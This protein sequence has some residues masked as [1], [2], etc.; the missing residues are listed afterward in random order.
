MSTATEPTTYVSQHESVITR[1]FDAPRE[2][3]FKAWTDP[4]QVARWWG[5]GRFTVPLCEM[6][7]RPGGAY[8][9]QMR[10]PDG[11]IYPTSGVFEEIV[12][13]ER[14]VFTSGA[15]E[16][17]QG[18][19]QL[20][21]RNTLTFS[22]QDGT[23]TLT[24]KAVVLRSTPEVAGALAGMEEGWNQSFDRLA[25][26]LEQHSRSTGMQT[27]QSKDGTTIAY[28]RS[29]NGPLL[30][31][32]DP[33][34]S[35][36]AD[37]PQLAALLAQNFTVI[38]YDR[39]GRGDSGDTQ[40]YAVEREVE[41]IEA[42]IDAAGGPV[43]IFG[44]SSGAA[45]ALEAASRLP[46]KISKAVLFEPPFIVDDSRPRVPEDYPARVAE[47]VAAGR[48]GDAVELFMG[49]AIGVPEEM[50]GYMKQDPSWAAMEAT[51]HTLTYDGQIMGDT[52]AGKPLP[53]D[54][55]A[56]ATADTLVIDG[57]LSEPFLRNA[58][59]AAADVLPN[60]QRRTLA[61]H[62]HSAVFTAPEALVPM[63]VEFL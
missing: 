56:T 16:D 24:L 45:L 17:Q 57:E 4:R 28:Q 3:V 11:A 54:R 50:L 36:R 23:T 62:D 22:E 31:V 58:A 21:A 55:W 15:F 49:K 13:P 26:Q 63:L 2:L 42:L 44:S 48:R 39:R 43:Y 7:V 46:A 5:P 6:D 18:N 37:A 61:G 38:N 10:A 59:Q 25:G 9:I 60:A 20:E 32:V 52:Q 1:V 19:M 40:P 51:A 53:A 35:T 33:A 34:L 27:V 12:A 8:L 41:D 14:L 29:G 47:L 30:I